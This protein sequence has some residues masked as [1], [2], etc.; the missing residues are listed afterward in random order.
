MTMLG[1]V[2][3]NGKSQAIRIPKGLRVDTDEVFIEKIGDTLVIKPK[4]KDKWDSF[5]DELHTVDTDGF[6]E[7]RVQLPLQERE[8]F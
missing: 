5:F 1:K 6:L 4:L 7:D 2:F 3:Q 8:L